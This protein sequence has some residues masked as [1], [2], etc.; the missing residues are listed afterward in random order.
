MSGE[1][2]VLRG[3]QTHTKQKIRPNRF[4]PFDPCPIAV[5]FAPQNVGH[6]TRRRFSPGCTYTTDNSNAP[7]EL[8]ARTRLDT[9]MS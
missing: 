1:I 5:M 8:L 3:R 2:T 9:V 7:R 4:Y 6:T